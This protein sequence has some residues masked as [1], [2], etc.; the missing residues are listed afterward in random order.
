MAY[1]LFEITPEKRGILATLEVRGPNGTVRMGE[2]DDHTW[3]VWHQDGGPF[4]TR[5][6]ALDC[7]RKIVGDLKD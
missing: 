1:E 7:A 4:A 6:E 3:M 5:G 2:A